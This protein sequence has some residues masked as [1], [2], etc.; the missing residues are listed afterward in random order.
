MPNKIIKAA[1]G[2]QSLSAVGDCIVE[3]HR[4]HKKNALPLE[5]DSR[6]SKESRRQRFQDY[7][8]VLSFVRLT[9]CE[10]DKIWSQLANDLEEEVVEKV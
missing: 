7:E 5:C 3:K 10:I 8:E 9:Q 2:K 1:T 4:K 6:N